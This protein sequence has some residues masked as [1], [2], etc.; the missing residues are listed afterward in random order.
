[1]VKMSFP[2]LNF[3]QI[4]NLE[5]LT[6]F[7]SE[8]HI[9]FPVL[10]K[11]CMEDFREF[12][13]F[14]S[15]SEDGKLPSLFNE[16]VVKNLAIRTMNKLKMI[17]N[18]ADVFR[19]L[20]ELRIFRC[21]NVMK[22][23]GSRTQRALGSLRGLD[24]KEC[25]K[26]EEV[27]E[28]Q[29]SSF[30][31]ITHD[32]LSAQLIHLSLSD[33]PN[34]RYVWGKDPQ[35]NITFTHLE[36]V[37]VWKCPSL[38][39]IFPLSIAKGLS[40]LR[41]LSLSFCGIQ[42]IVE[43]VRTTVLV[44]PEFVFPRLEEMKL[45][46]LENLVCIY[47]GLHTSSWPSLTTLV[48]EKCEKLKVLV[49]EFS[50]F[51]DKRVHHDHDNSPIPQVPLFFSKFPL[52]TEVS[53]S[54][55]PKFQSFV[56]K[57]EEKDCTTMTSLF[58]DKRRLHNLKRLE[59]SDCEMVEEVSKLK[60]VWSKDPQGTLTFPHL[61]EVT[62][63]LCPNLEAIFPASIAKG[64]FQLQTLRISDCGI[65][66]IVGKEEGLK[67]CMK[68]KDIASEFFNVQET[69]GSLDIDTLYG[70]FRVRYNASGIEYYIGELIL[71]GLPKLT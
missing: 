28:I 60:N 19:K 49:L 33:L 22:I 51:Q 55:C 52:L 56:S 35:G 58:N 70:R 67:M 25:A 34:L 36:Y 63:E 65:E 10:T 6:T 23:F 32:R 12:T 68:L 7:S 16:K 15:K 40:K 27:F 13:T 18:N 54:G 30:E 47:Q 43:A 44:P 39:S 38:K 53:I 2:K 37:K 1:M 4:G 8:I 26:I 21:D 3:L 57:L 50:C 62:A 24:M 69:H 31:E 14:I 9:D 11:L 45:Y 17:A 20:E 29:A 48:V 42:Q 59:I 41:K 46:H 61:K 66:Y 71:E 64:L 5:R